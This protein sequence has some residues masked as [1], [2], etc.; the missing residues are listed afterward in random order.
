MLTLWLPALVSILTVTIS[1]PYIITVLRRKEI[2]DVASARSSHTGIALRGVGLSV[3]VGVILGLIVGILALD[4]TGLGIILTVTFTGTLAALL[5]MIEDFRGLAIGIRA[6]I[7]VIIAAGASV[8]IAYFTSTPWLWC[9]PALVF[10]AGYINVANFMD[11]VDGISPIH[12]LVCGAFYLFLGLLIGT[13]WLVICGGV[14]AGSFLAF[15]PWNL[16]RK[17]TFLGDTGSYLLGALIASVAVSVWMLGI[18][19]VVAIGPA[20]IYCIDTGGTLLRRLFSGDQWYKPHRTH[21]YQRLTDAG[22]SHVASSSVVGVFTII[23]ALLSLLLAPQNDW[24]NG[25]VYGLIGS[26]CVLYWFTPLLLGKARKRQY[27]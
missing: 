10:I 27:V 2:V 5:G 8:A 4:G 25:L 21:V 23:V 15:L 13:P 18:N 16:R 7:Q 3:L 11:G 22:L 26:I 19:P 14:I 17:G 1:T 20:I 6:T 12:G 24:N 9:L